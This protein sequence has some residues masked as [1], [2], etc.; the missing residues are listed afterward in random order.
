MQ[1][2]NNRQWSKKEDDRQTRMFLLTK[3][4]HSVGSGGDGMLIPVWLLIQAHVIRHLLL[5][6]GFVDSTRLNQ[7]T[8]GDVLRVGDVRTET[9]TWCV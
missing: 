2:T 6:A 7:P 3:C 1:H 8:K 9:W 4:S 5:L